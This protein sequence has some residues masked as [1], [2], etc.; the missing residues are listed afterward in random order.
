MVPAFNDERWTVCWHHVCASMPDKFATK[1]TE[2]FM[3]WD[4]A[5]LVAESTDERSE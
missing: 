3:P 2:T 5:L 4:A 1:T